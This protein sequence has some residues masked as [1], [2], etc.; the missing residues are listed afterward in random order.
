MLSKWYE[1]PAKLTSL[2]MKNSIPV[3]KPQATPKD[4]REVKDENP[5]TGEGPGD[6]RMIT[7]HFFTARGVSFPPGAVASYFPSSRSICV[8]NTAANLK[9]IDVPFRKWQH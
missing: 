8:H 5:T 6:S 3:L 2:F 1:V 4:R 9:L 7:E